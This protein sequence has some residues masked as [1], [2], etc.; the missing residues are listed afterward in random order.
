MGASFRK[1]ILRSMVFGFTRHDWC[2]WWNFRQGWDVE[3]RRLPGCPFYCVKLAA[4]GAKCTFKHPCP[5]VI[6]RTTYS[7]EKSQSRIYKSARVLQHIIGAQH[8]AIVGSMWPAW[9]VCRAGGLHCWTQA[10][11]VWE[12]RCKRSR[13][14]FTL[15][16]DSVPWS[17]A[18]EIE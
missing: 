12:L 11:A 17:I 2:A 15:T 1:C 8:W 18:F 6:L 13:A 10:L 3:L 16:L 14:T 7:K 9:R 5:R 4:W